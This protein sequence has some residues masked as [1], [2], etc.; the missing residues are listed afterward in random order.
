MTCNH[1]H[2][3]M[4]KVKCCQSD[5][6]VV[7]LTKKDFKNGTYRI[8]NPGTYRLAECINFDPKYGSDTP[9]PD[10]PKNGFWFAAISIE[11]DNVILD[12]CGHEI[13][14]STY[15]QKKNL[16]GALALVLL[17]NSTFSGLLFNFANATYKGETEY[18]AANN[19]TIKNMRFGI[20]S[21]FAIRGENNNNVNI[22]NCI[23]E[24]AQSAAINLQ[25]PINLV[26]KDIKIYGSTKPVLVQMDKA[27]L[28]LAQQT[29][30]QFIQLGIPGAAEQLVALNK[31]AKHHCERFN[32]IFVHPSTNYGIFLYS[33]T[34]SLFEFPMTTT[35]NISANILSDG[36]SPE[37]VTINNVS[38]KGFK[39]LSHE[40][41]AIGTNIQGLQIS[42]VLLVGLIG[43]MQWKDAFD[44][45]NKFKPNDFL[46]SLAYIFNIIYQQLPPIFKLSLPANTQDIITSILT[47][48]ETLFNNNAAPI[49][50]EGDDGIPMKGLFGMRITA[51]KNV[52]IKD[53]HMEDFSS[54]GP[55]GIIPELLPGYNNLVATQPIVRFRGND[56]WFSSY[57]LTDDSKYY[58]A[59]LNDI[60]SVHGYT[61]GIDVASEDKNILID[62][63]TIKNIKAPNTDTSDVTNLGDAHGVSVENNV[64]IITIK[65]TTVN[66]ISAAGEAIPFPNPT[67]TIIL[68]NATINSK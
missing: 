53:I 39:T 55:V 62:C 16:V 27:Q 56:V 18:V 66:H 10:V 19:V 23:I 2:E 58:H 4:R 12:G 51:S 17:G 32:E 68:K 42:A 25:G 44:K 26:I 64:G 20:S 5:E 7:Y 31:Y 14:E 61:F 29:L 63:T 48:D 8:R 54:E 33:G 36:R 60:S 40:R 15:Y 6:N 38:L 24:E 43:I 52:N 46:K 65:N 50:G 13:R 1:K 34:T 49:V 35:T 45:N 37:N 21:H 30:A 11:T 28:Y 59:S 67:E 3:F 57:E 9:R 41:V 22:E 47:D